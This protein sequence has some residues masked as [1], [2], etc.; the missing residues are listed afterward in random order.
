MV[1]CSLPEL[2]VGPSAACCE[3]GLADQVPPGRRFVFHG[4]CHPCRSQ[5]L[6]VTAAHTPPETKQR[7]RTRH[8]KH[9]AC[10]RF[11]TGIGQFTD[12]DSD[13]VH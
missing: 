7:L 10:Q 8:G 13:K 5:I 2:E 9:L 3:D 6:L 1:I 11:T 12:H 4:G